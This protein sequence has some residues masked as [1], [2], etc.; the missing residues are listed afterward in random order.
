MKGPL[1]SYV[2]IVCNTM[3]DSILNVLLLGDAICIIQVNLKK[4]IK[5]TFLNGKNYRQQMP[6]FMYHILQNF[7]EWL[8]S[9]WC[10]N[11]ILKQIPRGACVDLV[12]RVERG[13]ER[14]LGGV[15]PPV[16]QVQ[17]TNKG[18]QGRPR[19]RSNCG[20]EV[21]KIVNNGLLCS[22]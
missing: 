1:H 10:T 2:L 18:H 11:V 20:R 22:W 12:E 3:K 7:I 6:Y 5:F 21:K 13:E 19:V 9:W 8:W 15:V 17:A 14:V 4:G 16:R